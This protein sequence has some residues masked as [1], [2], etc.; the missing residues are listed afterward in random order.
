M[1][2]IHETDAL[3]PLR[4]VVAETGVAQQFPLSVQRRLISET[5]HCLTPA[6]TLVTDPAAL[7]SSPSH[8]QWAMELIGLGFSLP[9]EDADTIS[10]CIAVYTAWLLDPAKRPWALRD[11][12]GSEFEQI[13]WQVVT[14]AFRSEEVGTKNSLFQRIFMH[15]SLLFEHRKPMGQADQ[16]ASPLDPRRDSLGSCRPSSTLEVQVE[17]CNRVLA[18]ILQ[19]VNFLA[20][21]FSP[22][23]WST[24]L[25]VVLS[26]ADV[27][28]CEPPAAC[29]VLEPCAMPSIPSTPNPLAGLVGLRNG[30]LKVNLGGARDKYSGAAGE[31]TGSVIGTSGGVGL[32]ESG[33]MLADELCEHLIRVG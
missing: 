22:A 29:T 13:V 21:R 20:P 31:R 2:Q 28:L 5:A 12:S 25:R 1:V 33:S 17:L 4:D 24:T 15:L 30:V 27:L 7:L 32:E 26:I 8:V 6:S 11:Q 18:L 23:T 3:W 14:S 10:D 16:T 19:A 9:I